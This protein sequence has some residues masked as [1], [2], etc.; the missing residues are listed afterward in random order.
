MIRLLKYLVVLALLAAVVLPAVLIVA[1]LQ[2]EPLVPAGA[3]LTAA[4][5][6]RAKA[7][8]EKYDPRGQ[9][10]GEVRS[11]VVSESDLGLMLNYGVGQLV[12]AGADVDL[13]GGAATIAMTARVPENP[14][15][16]YFNLQLELAQTP[17]GVRVDGLRAG[18]LQVPGLL[19]AGIG[20]LA[21]ETLR[22]DETFRAVI[23][24]V[25]GFRV[26]E[27]ALTVVYQWQPDVL[28]RV[29][30]R[31]RAMLI[32]DADR[33]RLLAYTGSIAAASRGSLFGGKTSLADLLGPVFAAARDR[34]GATGDAAAENRAA[35]LALML[36]VQGVDVQRLLGEPA[37]ESLQPAPRTLTLQARSDFAQH[38]L[39]SAGVAAAGGSRLADAVGLFK[40]IDD[41]RGGSGFSFTDLAADRAGVRF[42]ETATGPGAEKVQNL[43]ADG[44]AESVFMPEARDLPEFMPE[45]EFKRRFGGVGAP[46]YQRVA[47]EIEER[48]AAL[49]IHR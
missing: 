17:G 12:P 5:V 21:Q 19:A 44:A 26:G 14:L 38:F 16:R 10:A 29:K 22:R 24:S 4:D 11:L 6:G 39:I 2:T 41:S 33:E 1:G 15:G 3:R 27:G 20:W 25:N 40:E 35:I 30:S 18:T 23:A 7:L 13:R 9:G 28:D 42:A 36:Y 37:D 43:L 8:I 46:E 45:A 49:E 32:D 47:D 48:I 34:T 31:G